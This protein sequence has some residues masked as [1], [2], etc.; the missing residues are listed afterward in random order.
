MHVVVIASH[1]TPHAATFWFC[2]GD[3]CDGGGELISI[4][5]IIYYYIYYNI[6]NN[7]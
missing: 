3:V 5:N 6:Y 7:I 1:R 4:I 2:S